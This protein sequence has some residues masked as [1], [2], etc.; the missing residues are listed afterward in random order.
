M[1]AESSGSSTLQQLHQPWVPVGPSLC[2]GDILW[3]EYPS[4]ALCCCQAGARAGRTRPMTGDE[5]SQGHL[6]LLPASLAVCSTASASLPMA[7]LVCSSLLQCSSKPLRPFQGM[8]WQNLDLCVL[9]VQCHHLFVLLFFSSLFFPWCDFCGEPGSFPPASGLPSFSS[10]SCS[11]SCGGT[12][13]LRGPEPR[14]LS[15]RSMSRELLTCMV[16]NEAG[17]QVPLL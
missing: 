13:S 14:V 9:Q 2:S 6:S 5:M 3:Q 10:P 17:V 8:W 11:R 7:A 12:R 15:Q 4:P 1:T 16:S